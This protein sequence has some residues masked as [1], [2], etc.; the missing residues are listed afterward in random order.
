MDKACAGAGEV[1]RHWPRQHSCRIAEIVLS[2]PGKFPGT[3]IWVKQI[4]SVVGV[5]LLPTRHQ[6]S[7]WSVLFFVVVVKLWLPNKIKLR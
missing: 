6:K 7:Y 4:D 5:F 1:P 3:E 2:P